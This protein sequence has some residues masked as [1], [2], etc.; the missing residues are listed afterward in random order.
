M[1]LKEYQEHA[2]QEVKIFLEQLAAWRTKMFVDGEWLG[3]CA[4]RAWEKPEV[5]RSYVKRKD[6]VGR[7]LPTFCLKIPTGGGKTLLA[8]KTIDLVQNIYR[9]EQT[10]LV[11]WIVPTLQIYRQTLQRLKDRED[12]Y[13]QHLD[14]VSAGKTLILEK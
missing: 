4:E 2:L 9:Q 10:G 13:R 11:V 6:G 8:V 3:G 5:C 12:P 7:P 14:M 1:K